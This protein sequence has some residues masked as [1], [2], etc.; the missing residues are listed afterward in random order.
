MIAGLLV[1]N[2]KVYNGVNF[3]PISLGD[4]FTAYFGQNGAGKSSILEALDTFFNDRDW[5]IHRKKTDFTPKYSETSYIIPIFLIKKTELEQRTEGQ[6]YSYETCNKLSE[7]FWN[8]D[9][10]SSTAQ[11]IKTF[12]DY[13]NYLKPKYYNDYF[14]LPVG[15]LRGTSQGPY[16]G[17]FQNEKSF[18]EYF[19]I[20]NEIAKVT[21]EGDEED[22]D[23]SESDR[24]D[25]K[26][27]ED[28]AVA[29]YFKKSNLIKYITNH[30]Y[31]IYLPSEIDIE[32]Y[33]KLESANMQELVR[34]NVKDAILGAITTEMVTSINST[35]DDY[36]QEVSNDLKSYTYTTKESGNCAL[37]PEDF[38]RT[39]IRAYFSKRVLSKEQKNESMIPVNLLSS[40]E[41]RKALVDVTVTLLQKGIEDKQ[42]ILGI[43]EPEI[44]LHVSGCY[45]QFEKLR[46]LA[47]AG[48]QVL[49]TTHW[50]GFLPICGHGMA[51][52]VYENTNDSNQKRAIS[53]FSLENYLEEVNLRKCEESKNKKE[54][55]QN[56]TGEQPLSD[57]RQLPDDVYLKSRYDLV[58]AIVSSIR[59]EEQ[60][61]YL[62]VEGS[63]DK[64]YYENYLKPFIE[65]NNLRIL[66]VGGIDNV[67]GLL[68]YLRLPLADIKK[69]V[70]SKI[71]G[72]VDND[73]IQKPLD[74]SFKDSDILKYRRIRYD[75][76][77]KDIVLEKPTDK[78][79][80][81]NVTTVEDILEPKL[82]AKTMR[83]LLQE[84][85]MDEGL[86]ASLF[87]D[88][89]LNPY[90]VCSS[91]VID[92]KQSEKEKVKKLF[93]KK[94]FKTQFAKKYV[95]NEI[96]PNACTVVKELVN[97]FGFDESLLNEVPVEK[98][99]PK[100]KIIVRKKRTI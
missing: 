72:I 24:E 92:Y 75:S 59:S 86:D 90:S 80:T 17:S 35:L 88:D 21:Y 84:L 53:I 47:D 76:T 3:I 42:I 40:G 70:T 9:T 29:K 85:N 69:D 71:I 28:E 11:G 36:V 41:K 82:F 46:N 65:K 20:E 22:I 34:K 1:R 83:E 68:N 12:I 67:I 56:E 62:I 23:I 61:N 74:D 38:L 33:T 16:F 100:K 32:H 73:D 43:D 44:S 50:Y 54:K 48:S 10:T 96:K 51:C 81:G 79:K 52:N 66:A 91:D 14:I 6:K 77:T 7:Y 97:L 95:L 4:K 64:I 45:E 87:E 58:Q 25:D 63:S 78:N 19:Q 15:R 31:Y 49:I 39:I 27:K 2:Y 26:R 94:S 99:T 13:K 93:S 98:N 89:N 18:F 57:L 55:S 5:I 8:V 60:Y 30:Y 37:A